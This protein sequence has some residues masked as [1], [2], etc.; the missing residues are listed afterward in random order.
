[1]TVTLTRAQLDDYEEVLSG[2][3]IKRIRVALMDR[4][5][6]VIENLTDAFYGGD[7]TCDQAQDVDR[8]VSFQ[9]LDPKHRFGFDADTYRG[10]DLDLSRQVRL[11][12]VTDN[13]T[14]LAAPVSQAV[15]TGPVTRLR[16][17]GPLV[18]I[19]AQGPETYG[20]RPARRTLTL[21]KGML[22]TRAIRLILTEL[23]GIHPH[24]IAI[25]HKTAKLAETI[26]I[27]RKKLPWKVLQTLCKSL[28]C[29]GYFDGP[30]VFRLRP[31]P[32]QASWEFLG[33]DITESKLA[34]IGTIRLTSDPS[35]EADKTK[36]IN[37]VKVTGRVPKSPPKKDNND[38]AAADPDSS[39]NKK[40]KKPVSGH[41]VADHD[42]PLSPWQL[43]PPGAPEF[44]T[45]EINNDQFR[46]NKE[47]QRVAERELEDR[48]RLVHQVALTAPP[49]PQ[50]DLGD[51]IRVRTAQE[52]VEKRVDSFTLPLG[53]GG[54][55]TIGYG[56]NA[57]LRKK[58]KGRHP[59]GW[60]PANHGGL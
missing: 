50:M 2:L 59:N 18:T 47:C 12:W 22:R 17:E 10:G 5:G 1:M 20:L 23:M 45:L 30:G 49:V 35:I 52:T 24:R 26:S 48:L 43:G 8:S 33:S 19:E 32:R 38:K 4:R 39:D 6:T 16:R 14:V 60:R 55:M 28:D 57:P 9:V 27:T 25:P 15:I 36:V 51:L 34:T 46:T 40:K 56:A 41:A 37:E 29:Q 54:E 42:H 3:Y 21:K 7:L 31:W 44:L 13:P 58:G 53:L 11:W